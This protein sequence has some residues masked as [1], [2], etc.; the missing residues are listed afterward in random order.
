MYRWTK[1]VRCRTKANFLKIFL[2]KRVAGSIS[3]QNRSAALHFGIY[4]RARSKLWDFLNATRPEA[5]PLLFIYEVHDEP[6]EL[7]RVLDFVLR[8]AEDHTQHSTLFTQLNQDVAV[9][10]VKVFAVQV[11]E[12]V[13]AQVLGDDG[14]FAVRRFGLLVRHFQEEQEGE[15]F[16]VVT[17]REAVIAEEIAV[18]PE[19][20]DDSVGGHKF[21]AA[22]NHPKTR[23]RRVM[24]TPATALVIFL[25]LSHRLRGGLTSRRSSGADR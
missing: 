15:L 12:A 6:A 18:V 14:G 23:T 11:F 24:G 10:A 25:H 13:P 16:D 20:L 9:L 5:G 17:V 7:G 4:L 8:L 2:E 22:P 19:F 3:P 1:R 21:C